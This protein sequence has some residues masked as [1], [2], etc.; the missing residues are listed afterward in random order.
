MARNNH[1]LNIITT[2]LLGSDSTELDQT[3]CCFFV[4][5]FLYNFIF[6]LCVVD[7]A[8]LYQLFRAR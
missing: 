5:V 2:N 3:C 7:L 1:K 4:L 6:C 8:D